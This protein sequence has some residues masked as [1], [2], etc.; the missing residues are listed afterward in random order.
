MQWRVIRKRLI[1]KLNIMEEKIL[2]L[3]KLN[4]AYIAAI[5][6]D[7]CPDAKKAKKVSDL[8]ETGVSTQHLKEALDENQGSRSDEIASQMSFLIKEL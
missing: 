8:F 1:K 7:Y 2:N 6:F 5:E 4:A 3:K